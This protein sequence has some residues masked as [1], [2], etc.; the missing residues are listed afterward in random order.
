VL[1]GQDDAHR[2]AMQIV[3]VDA[4]GP[5]VRLV[6]PLV[7]QHEVDVAQRERRQRRLGL[8]FDELAAQPGSL[9]GQRAHR[10]RGQAQGDGLEGGDPPPPHDAAGGRRELRLGEL[11]PVEQ[12]VGVA[13]EHERRVGQADPSPRALEQRH[14]GLSLEHG[15]LLRHGGGR[16][17]QRVRDRGDRAA[18]VQL[19]QQAQAA[20]VKHGAAAVARTS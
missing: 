15:E 11:G 7:G 14:A 3:P 16:E 18:L 12:G 2:V 13:D 4:G 6:L 1:L 9:P 8:C 20:Q 19:V 10:R 17:L 5:R